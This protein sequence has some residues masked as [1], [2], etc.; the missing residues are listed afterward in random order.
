MIP[1]AHFLPRS[2]AD[3]S[4]PSH[5]RRW[6]TAFALA[7]RVALIT[8]LL[9]LCALLLGACRS[10]PKPLPEFTAVRVQNEETIRRVDKF[11]E[12]NRETREQTKKASD[13]QKQETEALLKSSSALQTARKM[14][15][16]LLN[17]D[18]K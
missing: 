2:P 1:R 4:A 17:E 10:A 7:A 3:E 13:A 5:L 11:S 16:E 15:A 18:E 9:A 6:L 14:L 12:Q 8:L